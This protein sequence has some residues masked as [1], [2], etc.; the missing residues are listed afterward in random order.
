[1]I[2][3]NLL[4]IPKV[5]LHLHIEGTLEPEMMFQLAQRNKVNL[6]Y[7]SIDEIKRAYNFNNLQD[8]L[9]LYYQGMS[10]ILTEQDFYDLTYA[11]LVKANQDNVTHS[12]IFIDPQAHLERGISLSIVFSGVTQAI[13]RA[14]KDFSIK[15]SI[16][17]CFLRHLSENHALCSFEKIMDFRESFI[18]IG[19]DSSELGNPPSKFKRVFEQAKKEGLYLV[20][21]AGEEGPVEYIWEA[22]D[23]LGVDRIDH[24]NAI[25]NDETLIQRII[26]DNIAL[27]MCP[28]SNKCLKVTSNLSD[29]PAAKLLEKGVKVTI[30][31]DDPAYFGGYLNENYRQIAQAL[32]LSEAQIIRLINNGLE[33]KF[34]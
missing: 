26:K 15:T 25:L 12:E 13:K 32:K 23:I 14:E 28:L 19:L 5:E 10:V 31:S 8:F 21:H 16:I 20:A 34:I 2:Y 18:G 22:I 7:G 33:A 3:E 9:D 1:M 27:T 11:Y 29:H 17:V 30:N 24:G 4:A 6:K